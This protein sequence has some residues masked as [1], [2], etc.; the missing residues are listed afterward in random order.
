MLANV[1]LHEQDRFGRIDPSRQQRICHGDRIGAQGLRL[2]RKRECVQIHD[3]EDVVVGLLLGYPVP[4]RAQIVSDVAHTGRLDTG[5]DPFASCCH[6]LIGHSLVIAKSQRPPL[7]AQ[8]LY[9][10]VPANTML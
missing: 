6:A 4:D 10:R 8:R 7:A 2:G 3:A 9:R 5:K 1:A